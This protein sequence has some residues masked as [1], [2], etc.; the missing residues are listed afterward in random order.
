MATAIPVLTQPQ[1]YV[2]ARR[3]DVQSVTDKRGA[4]TVDASVAGVHTIAAADEVRAVP[5]LLTLPRAR[6]TA[7]QVELDHNLAVSGSTQ[8]DKA[9]AGAATVSG[10]ITMSGIETAADEMVISARKITLH[11][12]VQVRGT[13]ATTTS[14]AL[15]VQDNV[16]TLG[17]GVLDDAEHDDAGLEL[18]GAPSN[19]PVGKALGLFDHS[20]KWMRQ[21]GNFTSAGAAVSPHEQPRWTLAGGGLAIAAPDA[22]DAMT[23]WFMAPHFDSGTAKLGLYF[24]R[25][26]QTEL[27]QEFSTATDRTVYAFDDTKFIGGDSTLPAGWSVVALD[28]Q[29]HM[30]ATPAQLFA[31]MADRAGMEYGF[32]LSTQTGTPYFDIHADVPVRLTKFDAW[33]FTWQGVQHHTNITGIR[34]YATNDPTWAKS[35]LVHSAGKAY[36]RPPTLP[37]TDEVNT[38]ENKVAVSEAYRTNWAD[39]WDHAS[40]VAAPSFVMFSYFRIQFQ[41]ASASGRAA[42]GAMRI[43]Y[44]DAPLIPSG[45]TPV[46]VLDAS[47]VSASNALVDLTDNNN[48]PTT[49][50][51]VTVK[52]HTKT[53]GLGATKPFDYMSGDAAAGFVIPAAVM[54]D[55]EYTFVH[56]TRYGGAERS[57]IWTS[58]VNN[59]LSGFHADIL[60]FHQV[61]IL[62]GDK[63]VDARNWRLT[64]DQRSYG[65]INGGAV[66]GSNELG[67]TPVDISIN[68]NTRRPHEFSAWDVAEAMLFDGNLDAADINAL[69]AYFV[70]KYGLTF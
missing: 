51:G 46:L 50:S 21:G 6:F 43:Y 44:D 27:V 2:A 42:L 15:V 25:N 14:E 45:R 16:L 52:K 64:V 65:R 48:D 31:P 1:G 41:T 49:V 20:L 30:T 18:P 28:S 13:V 26:G 57:R 47:S 17:G 3:I 70:E 54:P 40:S 53:D 34:V 62:L 32:Y 58:T 4:V 39:T 63:T 5:T 23:K 22:T 29:V 55:G 9:T 35:V 7:T 68:V 56:L 24:Q 67:Q 59:F 12:D 36:A 37:Y 61:A 11:A 10:A 19:L 60:M 69:E 66:T 8:A 33:A 38:Y